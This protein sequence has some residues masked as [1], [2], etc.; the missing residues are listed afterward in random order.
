MRLM[1]WFSHK[2]LVLTDGLI[3]QVP[4]KNKNLMPDVFTCVGL[5][6][7]WQA[8]PAFPWTTQNTIIW[9]TLSCA[10]HGA[11]QRN[12]YVGRPTTNKTCWNHMVSISR[13]VQLVM[14]CNMQSWVTC[15]SWWSHKT[16]QVKWILYWCFFMICFKREFASASVKGICKTPK[17]R[18]ADSTGIN[19]SFSFGSSSY[20]TDPYFSAWR[21]EN[22]AVWYICADRLTRHVSLMLWS[23]I[24]SSLNLSLWFK[25]KLSLRF[26]GNIFMAMICTG[27]FGR[28]VDWQSD[29]I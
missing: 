13:S 7:H 14:L 9:L 24:F 18:T 20:S 19:S 15:S 10:K 6:S 5:V 16:L 8:G 27:P 25:L 22:R 17:W 1:T 3:S 21:K 4:L 12:C 11:G 28:E 26:S 23:A 2:A 29:L